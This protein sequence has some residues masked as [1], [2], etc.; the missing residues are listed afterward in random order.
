[1]ATLWERAQALQN[2]LVRLR[3]AIHQRPELGFREVETA[4]L[5]AD[6]LQELGLTAQ[7]GVGKTG[8]VADLG[9]GSPCIGVRA[10]MDALPI[11][12][13][14]DV[15]YRSQIPGV[16]H[17]CGHDA[18]VAMALGVAMLLLEEDLPGRVRL[19]FQPSE[20]RPDEE[21]VS[22]A[23][24]MIEDGALEGVD[25]VIAL[26]VDSETDTGRVC[27]GPGPIAATED[28]FRAT[29]RGVGCHGASPHMG[30]DPIFIAGPLLSALHGIVSRHVDPMATAVIS[31][32]MI[33]GGTQVNV[34][35]AEVT[36]AGTIRSF[37]QEVRETLHAE[38]RRAF[39]IVPALGGEAELTIEMDCIALVNDAR[40]SDLIEGVARDLLGPEHVLP[41][42]PAM[43]AE[44]FGYMS[45]ALPAAMFLL[46]VRDG[47]IRVEHGAFF[48]IDEAALPVGTA[49]LAQSAL[50]YLSRHK[51]RES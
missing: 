3:R 42:R 22:G 39:D 23:A 17:A 35:P 16:M 28:T 37:E 47:E 31:V 45:Q 6:T 33:Q 41:A 48:D 9:Q 21:G 14:N 27:V 7:T 24:R 11:E 4:R 40:M 5:I 10:D 29:V 30:R 12:E 26:H 18:H 8:V 1:M 32:G 2:E 13:Q 49:I 50:R 38:L 51:D 34:I 20:E 36:L 25:A 43:G 15:P 19:L 46:G 44:D